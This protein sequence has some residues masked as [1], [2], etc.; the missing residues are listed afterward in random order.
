MKRLTLLAA[1]AALGTG[2]AQAQTTELVIYK[3]A[4]FRGQSESI[5]GE[6][7]NLENGFGREV[8]SLEA[9]GGSWEVCTSDHFKGR[10]RVLDEGRYPTLNGLNDR[11]VS[12]RFLGASAKVARRDDRDVR[13]DR[14]SR[15]E[16]DAR[17][18]REARR[19]A[20]REWREYNDSRRDWDSNFYDRSANTYDR[21]GTTYDRSGTTYYER[22]RS[23]YR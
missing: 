21:S 11:I 16:R 12:V 19:E 18:A 10:C 7:A 17:E 3:E 4:N 23:N 1:I 8:S 13:N 15:E 22:P 6:V 14:E 5:K 2:V 9:K 20:R